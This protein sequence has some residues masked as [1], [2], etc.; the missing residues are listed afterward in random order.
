MKKREGYSPIDPKRLEHIIAGWQ[1]YRETFGLECEEYAELT[2]QGYKVD[3][4]KQKLRDRSKLLDELLPL[5][6]NEW[7]NN[8]KE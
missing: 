3:I 8:N 4:I 6:E 2:A 1:A 5:W 7:L